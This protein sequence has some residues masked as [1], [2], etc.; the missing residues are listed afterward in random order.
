M[1]KNFNFIYADKSKS[2]VEA[3]L[4]RNIETALHEKYGQQPND[5]ITKR[6]QQEWHAIEVDGNTMDV[7]ILHELCAW[8]K[9]NDYAYWLNGTTGGSFILYLLGVAAANPLPAHFYCPKC[10]T[11]S[12]VK[13]YKTGFDLSADLAECCFDGCTR[14]RDGHDIP[15]QT[16]WGYRD[17]PVSLNIRID[18]SLREPLY[19][20]FENHWLSKI[21]EHNAPSVPYPEH[22][23]L[24]CFSNISLDAIG[25]TDTI[26][27]DFHKRVVDDTAISSALENWVELTDTSEEQLEV[28]S[29]PCWFGNLLYILGL[30]SS[31]GTWDDDAAFM[32]ESLGY[33]PSDLI[34]FRDD[35][36]RY[37][38]DHDFTEKD[39]WKAA[40]D[41]RKGKGLPFIREEMFNSRDLWVST[42]LGVVRYLYPKAHAV[43]YLLFRIKCL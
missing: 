36:F 8:M 24:F 42:R 28:L 26:P 40:E 35:V 18:P 23:S 4:L 10:H 41:V 25:E 37:M 15:W 43:E 38:L 33:S 1:F 13:H 3:D 6:V 34:A 14:I 7:A 2:E 30:N 39:A 31:T 29:Q 32:I 11:V 27:K 5:E 21:E 17:N 22:N 19:H 20:F 12:W 9:D 16:L